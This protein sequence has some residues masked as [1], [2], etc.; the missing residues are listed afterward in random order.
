MARV[1]VLQHEAVIELCGPRRHRYP[2][3]PYWMV[4]MVD[5]YERF[6]A[7]YL[8]LNAYF[9]VTN[10]IVHAH[11]RSRYGHIGNHT[12][13]DIL[14]IRMPYSAERADHCTSQMTRV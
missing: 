4:P 5:K 10:F 6:I 11:E 12:E 2:F 7:S 8:R 9:T 13:T 3:V 14:G 1:R